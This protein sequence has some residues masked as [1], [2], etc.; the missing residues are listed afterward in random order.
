DLPQAK[1]HQ[2]E[3]LARDNARAGTRLAFGEDLAYRYRLDAADVLLALDADLLALEPGHVRYVHDFASRRRPR[4][5]QLAL[6]RVYAVE[7]TPSTVGA[8]ADHRLPLPARQIEPFARALAAALGV[9]AGGGSPPL[10]PG[11]PDAWP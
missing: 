10:P 9:S 5:D 11:V 6:S 7:S 3:P 1:W 4:P 8:V 2:Y